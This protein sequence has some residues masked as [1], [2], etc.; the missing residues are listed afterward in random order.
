MRKSSSF[1][2]SNNPI[3]QRRTPKA[4]LT[5]KAAGINELKS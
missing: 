5:T 2:D 4:V 3:G 1:V